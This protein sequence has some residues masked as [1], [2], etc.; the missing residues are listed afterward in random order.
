MKRIILALLI[1]VSCFGMAQATDVNEGSTAIL[2]MSFKNELGIATVPTTIQY[3]IDNISMNKLIKDWTSITP[4]SSVDLEITNLENAISTVSPST[5]EVRRVTVKWTY[6][7]G[8]YG[9]AE[10]NYN[11]V[12]LS[13][14]P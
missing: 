11:V 14:L 5:K 6:A 1:I 10:Y 7:I 2:T 3:R 13:K 8:K 9:T 12:N 4:G